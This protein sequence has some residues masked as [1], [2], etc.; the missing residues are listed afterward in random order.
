VN[1]GGYIALAMFG[2]GFAAGCELLRLRR[3][4]DVWAASPPDVNYCGYIALAMFGCGFAAGCELLRLR[5]SGDVWLRLRRR[6]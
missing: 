6:M 3:S 4:G 2:C 5:R 1:Y